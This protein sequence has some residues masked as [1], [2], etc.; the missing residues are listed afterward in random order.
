MMSQQ[1]YQDDYGDFKSQAHNNDAMLSQDFNYGKPTSTQHKPGRQPQSSLGGSK[2]YGQG[3]Q[4]SQV[5]CNLNWGPTQTVLDNCVSLNLL[6]SIVFS[7]TRTTID[8]LKFA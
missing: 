5:N 6:I 8:E 2:L 7:H 3:S 4:F 1:D